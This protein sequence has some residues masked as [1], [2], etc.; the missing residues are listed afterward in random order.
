[1]TARRL[2]GWPG[3]LRAMAA[4]GSSP[5]RILDV[6]ARVHGYAAP[7]RESRVTRALDIACAIEAD[8]AR[9]GGITDVDGRA[10]GERA[11]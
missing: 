11:A 6:W 2:N 10:P 5:E 7:R 1:M 9:A 3:M 4:G 8:E